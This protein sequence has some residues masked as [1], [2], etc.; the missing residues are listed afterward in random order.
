M[1]L[2]RVHQEK[3]SVPQ[4]SVSGVLCHSQSFKEPHLYCSFVTSP[5]SNA[6]AASLGWMEQAVAVQSSQAQG[7]SRSCS[8]G[9]MPH[10]PCTAD[11]NGES[12]GLPQPPLGCVAKPALARLLGHSARDCRGRRGQ[13]RADGQPAAELA[14]PPPGAL[15][16]QQSHSQGER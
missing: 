1:P 12:H 10:S 14:Q 3:G 13:G 15:A 8:V 9:L 16:P 11:A 5:C 7:S 6:Q 4:H 2:S